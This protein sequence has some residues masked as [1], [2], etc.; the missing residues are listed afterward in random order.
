MMRAKIGNGLELPRSKYVLLR[1]VF[2]TLDLAPPQG[3]FLTRA[4]P[5]VETLG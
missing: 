4:I 3:V 5:R 1:S 2:C